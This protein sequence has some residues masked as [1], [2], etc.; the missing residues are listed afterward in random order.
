MS[1]LVANKCMPLPGELKDDTQ[2]ISQ[3]CG[4]GRSL[5]CGRSCRNHARGNADDGMDDN[6][7]RLREGFAIAPVPL[8]L[9]ASLLVIVDGDTTRSFV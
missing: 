8:N 6:E 3:V 5:G 2:A 1:H 9:A 4:H 7:S